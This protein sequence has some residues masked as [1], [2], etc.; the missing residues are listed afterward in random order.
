MLA[1]EALTKL[2]EEKPKKVLNIGD[3]SNSKHT[4]I[5]EKNGIEVFTVNLIPP[6]WAVLPYLKTYCAG[7]ECIWCSHVLEHQR[8]PGMFLDK[9][10]FDLND[11]GLLVITV[12]PAKNK[13]A[14]GHVTI[15][16]ETVLLYQLIVAGFDC[17][18]ATV[19]RYDYNISVIVKKKQTDISNLAYNKGD[20]DVIRSYMPKY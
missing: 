13:L 1:N 20:L 2:I 5:M 15:W 11:D 7:Q 18:L 19:M 17:R 16:N 14:G 4:M 6:A 8:N 3:T 9:I 12:P 10:F